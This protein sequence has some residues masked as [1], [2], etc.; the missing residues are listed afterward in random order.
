MVLLWALLSVQVLLYSSVTS[1]GRRV[2]LSHFLKR[3]LKNTKIFAAISPHKKTTR[4]I[5]NISPH[6]S[7]IITSYI[8]QIYI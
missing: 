6:K 1:Q 5:G 8:Y 7:A 2:F 3:L 4:T